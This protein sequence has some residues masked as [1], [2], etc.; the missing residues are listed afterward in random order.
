MLAAL[1]GDDF[2]EAEKIKDRMGDAPSIGVFSAAFV[3]AVQHFIGEGR[4]IREITAFVGCVAA[5]LAE[6]DIV[7]PRRETEAAIR[8]V[9]G[10]A[11]LIKGMDPEVLFDVQQ[12]TLRYLAEDRHF[13]EAFIVE[14]VAKAEEM[15]A[16]WRRDATRRQ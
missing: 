13:D 10:E 12:Y 4:D 15:A 16:D 8:A 5:H 14:L 7:V 1:I 2:D 3:V 11:Y 9:F 6:D